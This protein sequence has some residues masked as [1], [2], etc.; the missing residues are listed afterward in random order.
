[1]NGRPVDEIFLVPGPSER[2]ACCHL[3]KSQEFSVWRPYSPVQT[4]NFLHAGGIAPVLKISL[5]IGF[6][7]R[8]PYF[9]KQY[10][11]FSE[12]S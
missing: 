9:I 5:G 2:L 12:E 10:A 11:A 7:Q 3:I 8:N 4:N 6:G 1:V